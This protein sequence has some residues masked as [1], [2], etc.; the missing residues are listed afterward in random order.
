MSASQSLQ[1]SGRSIFENTD[2][3]STAFLDNFSLTDRSFDISKPQK[4][5][6]SIQ[7]SD[8]SITYCVLDVERNKYLVIENIKFNKALGAGIPVEVMQD[9]FRDNEVLSAKFKSVSAAYVNNQ[10][11]LVPVAIYDKSKAED[12]LQLNLD[13]DKKTIGLV[14]PESLEFGSD[15]IREL[16]SVNLYQF[17]E[18]VKKTL[19]Q[20]HPK[21]V[22]K[23]HSSILIQSAMLRYKNQHKKLL[24]VHFRKDAF[25]IL[26]I[27]DNQLMLY[28]SFSCQSKEDFVYYIL[29]ACEQLSLNPETIE[30]EILGELDRHSP[31]YSM[32]YTYIRNISVSK[33]PANF[34]YSYQFEDLPSH[35]YYNLFSQYLCV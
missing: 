20:I 33:R 8:R 1:E 13:S 12:F 25:E 22:I 9:A 32:L 15:T 26:V 28:N 16:K 6:L 14:I 17:P 10:A 7:L 4:Y 5:H 24:L 3:V 23:H 31:F 35:Y 30:T 21:V 27:D 18:N 29:F 11:T 34:E 19:R 2:S